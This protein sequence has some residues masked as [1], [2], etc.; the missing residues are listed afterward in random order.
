MSKFSVDAA[1]HYYV[2]PLLEHPLYPPCIVVSSDTGCG[3]AVLLVWQT[4][5]L[6]VVFTKN[7]ILN[8]GGLPP[9]LKSLFCKTIVLKK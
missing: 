2:L 6:G 1:K 7:G 4:K 3:V 5:N 9:C 8:F